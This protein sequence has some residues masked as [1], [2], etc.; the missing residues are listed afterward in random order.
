MSY[1]ENVR[2]HLPLSRGDV[3][4]LCI[5]DV[6]KAHQLSDFKEPTTR[7]N[8]HMRYVPAGYTSDLQPLDLSGNDEFKKHIKN[9]CSVWYVWQIRSELESGKSLEAIQIDLKLSTLKPVHTGWLVSV[10]DSIKSESIKLGWRKSG[11]YGR[12]KQYI[13]LLFTNS[14]F[15]FS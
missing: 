9:E 15:L 2:K 3:Q 5:F 11:I 1:V 13:S 8:I 12:F 6:F 4:A 10:F 7:N 14:I